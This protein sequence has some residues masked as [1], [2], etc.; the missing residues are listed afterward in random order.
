[1]KQPKML[2]MIL[3][4]TLV[5][6]VGDILLLRFMIIP[7]LSPS[8]EMSQRFV[9]CAKKDNCV[10]STASADSRY[11]VEAIDFD[12]N[13]QR[14]FKTLHTI[15]Q[16]Q[17]DSK[18]VLLEQNYARFEVRSRIMGFI[19]DVE[20]RLDSSNKRI[21]IRSASRL[22]Y[23]DFGVNRK[24]VERYRKLFAESF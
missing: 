19:D 20:I 14:A 6:I 17:G 24:R 8:P 2:L 21:D 15:I 12:G 22:G 4:F 18:S 9:A 23:S 10:S 16:E 1:M 5:I 11:F 7:R 3:T 13:P